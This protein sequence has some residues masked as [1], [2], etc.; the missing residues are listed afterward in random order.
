MQVSSPTQPSQPTESLETVTLEVAGMKCAGCVS[1]VERQLTQNQGVASAWVNLVTQMA[2][3]KYD[4]EL[5]QPGDLAAKLTSKGFPSHIRNSEDETFEAQKTRLEEKQKQEKR[6]Q[7]QQLAIAAVLLF[8][9]GLGHLG[10]WGGPKIPFLSNIWLHWALATLALLFPGRD[11]VR[12]GARGLWQR[13]PNMN[14]LVGLGTVTTYLASCAALF[15]PQ[16]GWQCFFDE[17][18]MLL[19]FI[20]LGRILEQRAKGRAASALRALLTLQP[21]LAYLV[22]QPHTTEQRGMATPVEQVKEGELVRVLPGDKIPVDGQVVAGETTVDEGMLT[23]EAA[24]VFKQVGEE[25][26]AGTI[27]QSGIIILKTIR[28]GKN[29]TLAQIINLVEAAQTSK[30]P[31]QKLVDQVAGYFAYG[32]MTVAS[33]TF[34]FWYVLGTSLW[35]QVLVITATS[36][37]LLSLKLAIAVLVIACPCALGLATPTA[38]LVGTGIGAEKGILIKGGDVLER[39]NQLDSIVFDKTGTLTQGHPTVTD[40][41][42]L[43]SL[44]SDQLLQIVASAESG[45]NHP[46]ATAILQEAHLRELSLLKSD[47]FHTEPGQGITAIVNGEQVVLGNFAWLESQG[48]PVDGQVEAKVTTLAT[49]GKTVVYCSINGELTGL[50][51]LKDKLRPQ[52]KETI[53]KLH[54][55]GLEVILLTGDRQGV[56]EQVATELGI[57]QVFAGI[58]PEQKAAIIK[59]LQESQVVAMVGDGINDAPALA[60]ADVGIS[61][62]GG[63][64]VAMETAG[65]ILM[66]ENL[67][68]V[69]ESLR[70]SLATLNKIRQNL[71]W[72]LG[73]NTFAI[74]IAAGIL[75]PHWGFVLSPGLAGGLMAASSVIVVTNSLL[76]RRSFLS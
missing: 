57:T 45:T 19:G 18:V 71:F 21:P 5:I 33:L 75:L 76:L 65:I 58:K 17:P 62:Q 48:I 70:L 46:L 63:T 50:I 39:I 24:P 3:V 42:S 22:S 41:L 67:F 66:Q 53:A 34:F 28:T 52:A 51:A 25:V 36:P 37:L 12:D 27:N 35:P 6:Q 11:I 56:A 2:V 64:D 59:S 72:A 55:R 16:L 8:F 54:K 26:V 40:C 44:S 14:T 4:A 43:T 73:Y 68:N 1:S 29:T 15:F 10:H 30:A 32:V 20:L 7:R 49:T 31:V 61:L 23:G 69:V 38:I 47:N 9:S 60:Q 13:I 74:P